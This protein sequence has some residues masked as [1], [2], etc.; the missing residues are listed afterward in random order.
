MVLLAKIVSIRNV[1]T[2]LPK[3]MT[4]DRTMFLTKKRKIA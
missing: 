3:S 1:L 2:G 4:R